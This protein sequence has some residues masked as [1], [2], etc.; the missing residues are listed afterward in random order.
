MLP[1]SQSPDEDV[2][3]G[4][5]AAN[6]RHADWCHFDAICVPHA[7]NL[8]HLEVTWL[9]RQCSYLQPIEVLEG[10]RVEQGGFPSGWRPHDGHQFAFIDVSTDCKCELWHI[11]S[12]ITALF[13]TILQNLS[14]LFPSGAFGNGGHVDVLPTETHFIHFRRKAKVGLCSER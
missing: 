3:L 13:I 8:A 1:H 5:V 2:K 10:E 4:N 12:V 14:G 9:R 6:W 7:R 11:F